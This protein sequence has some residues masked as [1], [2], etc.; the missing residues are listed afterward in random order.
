MARQKS[1][2][3]VNQ[4]LFGIKCDNDCYS[5]LESASSYWVPTVEHIEQLDRR[6]KWHFQ[7]HF[8]QLL[9]LGTRARLRGGSHG[10]MANMSVQK[11][12][13]LQRRC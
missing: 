8:L 2:T 1:A 4:L 9:T 11:K 3:L 13:I 7:E 12:R 6:Y 10:P 5:V